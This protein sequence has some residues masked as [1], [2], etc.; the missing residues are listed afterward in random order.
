MGL[1]HTQP[2]VLAVGIITQTGTAVAHSPV[3][4]AVSVIVTIVAGVTIGAE[5]FHSSWSCKMMCTR[6]STTGGSPD[7]LALQVYL[8][9]GASRRGAVR[10]PVMGA[11]DGFDGGLLSRRPAGFRSLV[12]W[13]TRHGHGDGSPGVV[14]G[15]EGILAK[16]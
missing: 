8:L 15:S 14:T 1:A 7:K 13:V 9:R 6:W 5:Y 3:W 11:C 4:T 10:P 16:F 12:P 2:T